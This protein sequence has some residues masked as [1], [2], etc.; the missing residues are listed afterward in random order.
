MNWAVV[1]KWVNHKTIVN[2]LSLLASSPVSSCVYVTLRKGYPTLRIYSR[3]LPQ[4]PRWAMS[5][6]KGWN[7]SMTSPNL[8]NLTTNICLFSIPSLDY[9]IS[10][11]SISLE[12]FLFALIALP[13]FFA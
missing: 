2:F 4:A 8:V 5:Q 6:I 3:C 12:P 7:P 10:L 1:A 11:S 13:L 9:P